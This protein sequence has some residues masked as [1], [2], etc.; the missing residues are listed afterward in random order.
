MH[1]TFLYTWVI[2]RQLYCWIW[3]QGCLSTDLYPNV[4]G[5]NSYFNQ[6]SNTHSTQ[7]NLWRHSLVCPSYRRRQRRPPNN[8]LIQRS[9]VLTLMSAKLLLVPLTA[10]WT[11]PVAGLMSGHCC[12]SPTHLCLMCTVEHIT[13]VG[14]CTC[15]PKDWEN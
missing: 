6:Y 11:M 15:Q 4:A 8:T 12:D 5:W 14:T 13:A 7:A 9:N 3:C 1:C 10:L 2:F